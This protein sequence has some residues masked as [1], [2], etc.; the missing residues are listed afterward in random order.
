MY[1]HGMYEGG[2]L[3]GPRPTQLADR[4]CARLVERAF[5]SSGSS[6]D[7]RNRVQRADIY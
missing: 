1:T 7:L 4:D 2:A 5:C 3:S 6:A